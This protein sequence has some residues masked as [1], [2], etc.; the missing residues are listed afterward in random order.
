[1]LELVRVR[2]RICSIRFLPSRLGKI[3][4][5]CT[6]LPAPQ[7]PGTR[8]VLTRVEQLAMI[9]KAHKQDELGVR[10][11]AVWGLKDSN[12]FYFNPGIFGQ[13]R[14]GHGAAGRRILG[15]ELTVDRIH[16]REIIHIY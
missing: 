1:M 4:R 3:S 6:E 16:L 10:S 14:H 12:C 5:R 13:G 7:R 2:L 9:L 15:K 8:Y 11:I